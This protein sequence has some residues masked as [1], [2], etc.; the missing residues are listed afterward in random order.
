MRLWHEYEARHA[1]GCQYSASCGDDEA[2]LGRRDAVM[3]FEHAP[4]DELF[5]DYAGLTMDI[6]DRYSGGVQ[7]AQNFVADGLGAHA[8]NGLGESWTVTLRFP[9]V[10][11]YKGLRFR[12][13]P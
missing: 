3:R 11:M 8:S 1:D 5:V 6:V 2:W 4:G 10:S 7:V 12:V 9:C 13:S